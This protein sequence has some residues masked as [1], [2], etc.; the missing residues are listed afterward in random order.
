MKNI[1]IYDCEIIKAI[2]KKNEEKILNIE[3]CQ[4][5]DDHKNMGVSVMCAYD[6]LY[7]SYHV[8]CEDNKEEFAK[9]LAERKP[10]CAGF[11]NIKFD[12]AL[13]SSSD[14]PFPSDSDC[15]DLLREIWI[16]AGFGVE[17]NFETHTGYGLDIMCKTN[18]GT[19]KNGNGAMAPV[20]WQQGRIGEV[21]NYCLNDIKLTKQLFDEVLA[22]NALKNPKGGDLVLRVPY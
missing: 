19:E 6:Y 14:W 22:G 1:I 21:I 10:L 13:L 18:F 9:I 3:Y 8:Y 16:A 12:N 17:F 2:P 15:Y 11:N 4:G 7:D 20:L 5:W